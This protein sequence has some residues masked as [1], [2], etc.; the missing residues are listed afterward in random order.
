MG[1]A[2]ARVVLYE[3]GSPAVIGIPSFRPVAL[4]PR[5]STGLPL[6]LRLQC[7]IVADRRQVRI[8]C[9]GSQLVSRIG[10]TVACGGLCSARGRRRL[11]ET[12]ARGEVARIEAAREIAV[13]D[14]LS[15]TRSVDEAAVTRKDTDVID[16]MP[17]DM[18]EDQVPWRELL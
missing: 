18:E 16:A 13:G 4:R 8:V 12:S 15:G 6:S 5:L 3:R 9:R 7:Q 14:R 1:D 10:D 2:V 17:A 11:P